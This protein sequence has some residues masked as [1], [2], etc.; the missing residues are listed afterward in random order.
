MSIEPVFCSRYRLSR[1]VLREAMARM[2][3]DGLIDT[4][5]GRGSFVLAP[6]AR[7]PFR[8]ESLATDAAGSI[9]KLTELRFSVQGTAA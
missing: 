2:K 5:Q 9:S 7:T 8:F 3:S 4:N 6:P 1:M